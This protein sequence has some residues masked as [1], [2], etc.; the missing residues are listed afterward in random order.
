MTDTF[1]SLLEA[2]KNVGVSRAYGPPVQVG[3]AELLPVALVSFGFG[4]GTDAEGGDRGGA[5]GGGAS[6][7][8]GGG[9]VLPLGAYSRE[10][11]GHLV[12]RPNTIAVLL[13]IVPVVTAAGF[14]VRGAV[15]AIRS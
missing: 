1:S 7:G 5:S 13:S 3:G 2:F 14:A 15:R 6:G 8:G 10:S 11:G 12:F 4:G 9:F